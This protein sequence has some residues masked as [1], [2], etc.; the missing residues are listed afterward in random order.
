MRVADYVIEFL[1]AKGI[2]HPFVVT[3]RGALFLNDALAK[4]DA[5][6][7]VFTHHEQAAAFAAVGAADVTGAPQ[8]AIVS[9]GCASTNVITGVLSAWQD[10]I[11]LIVISGQ[12]SLKETTRHTGLPI[13]TY[14][15]QEADIIALVEPICKSA[16]MLEE[17]ARIRYELEKMFHLAMDGNKGPVWLDVPIDIQNARIDPQ[18]LEGFTAEDTA[19]PLSEEQAEMLAGYLRAAE[20]PA[21][22]IGAG[23]R[24]AGPALEAFC[25]G[26]SIPIVYAASAVDVVPSSK[27]ISIGSVG[28]Q[29]CS[30]QGAFTVQNADLLIVLGSRLNS[31]T[32][33][34]DLCDFAR[35]AK[36][37]VVDINAEE[38]EKDGARIDLF[39]QARAADVVASLAAHDLPDYA[40]WLSR[41]RSWKTAFSGNPEFTSRDGLV[42]LY[43]VATGLPDCLP[44]HGAFVCDSG[45]IDVIVP[46]N[47]AFKPGQR[48]VRPVSQGAM[49]FALPAAIGVSRVSDRPVLCMVGDGSIMMNL[50]ELETI[51][52]SC[53][54]VKII[55]VENG[56]YAIIR[57]R[58]EQ[59]F[60]GRTVGVDADT[61]LPT[62]NFEAIAAAFGLPFIAATA[63]TYQTT[64]AQAFEAPGPMLITLP[65]KPNQSYIEIGYGRDQD[66]R[67]AR[68]PLEDQ[69]PFLDRDVFA[70]YMAAPKVDA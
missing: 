44:D 26:H 36:T 31:L 61:G 62:P 33:G 63:A 68:R 54:N 47:A 57:R 60:R 8:A 12:N 7:P 38:H 51:A 23:A 3:G 52:R 48:V 24:A 34:P 6:D 59:L 40:P 58:Q 13:K 49:G 17:P 22:L 41:A 21:V 28:S 18:G 29:G 14:G 46:T 4:S 15:Q 67:L 53:A 5:V 2:R 27:A 32:T 56:M 64:L 11:P 65:G 43:D 16:V 66:G 37:V 50:Q 9:T 35:N 55:V 42:D 25:D 69:K 45:F 19:F 20:R 30:R 70:A 10:H 39:I 1:A